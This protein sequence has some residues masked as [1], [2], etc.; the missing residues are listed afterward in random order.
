MKSSFR[1]CF[2]IRAK[3]WSLILCS[4]LRA[5]CSS[6][7]VLLC[8][9]HAVC[10]LLWLSDKDKVFIRQV[11]RDGLCIQ[12]QCREIFHTYRRLRM[13]VHDK[14]IFQQRKSPAS[15]NIFSCLSKYVLLTMKM[16]VQT[17]V[18]CLFL[19]NYEKY[20]NQ[21]EIRFMHWTKTATQ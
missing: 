7:P 10:R 1:T 5:N 6:V 9:T 19:L 4:E 20:Q 12:T 2:W 15:T 16:N 3:S 11:L 14:E 8:S 13:W 18:C 21:I 17:N